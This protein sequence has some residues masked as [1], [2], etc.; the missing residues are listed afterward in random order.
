MH[1]V[2]VLN[3]TDYTLKH[4]YDGK[5]I[6]CAFNIGRDLK[7]FF[8]SE[9]MKRGA[10][11]SREEG[12]EGREGGKEKGAGKEGGKKGE[13]KISKRKAGA[14]GGMTGMIRKREETK[15]KEGKNAFQE[16]TWQCTHRPTR[17]AT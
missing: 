4:G 14:R 2:K 1:H 8:K 10:S 9:G 11:R 17:L 3:T 12:K 6:I 5:F 15:I 7:L 13:R 16:V